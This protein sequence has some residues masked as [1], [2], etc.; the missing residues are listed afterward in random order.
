MVSL[1]VSMNRFLS[2]TTR[3]VG[4]RDGIAHGLATLYRP[5]TK[6]R[7]SPEGLDDRPLASRVSLGSEGATRGKEY[8]RFDHSFG[9]TCGLIW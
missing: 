2:L 5:L 9:G 6:P 1:N 7:W 4:E 3:V 8:A